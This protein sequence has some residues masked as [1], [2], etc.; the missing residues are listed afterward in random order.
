MQKYVDR[1][2]NITKVYQFSGAFFS[3]VGVIA[4]IILS[5]WLC[6]EI[7]RKNNELVANWLALTGILLSVFVLMLGVSYNEI[8]SC[9]SISYTYLSGTYPLVLAFNF[10]AIF[11]IIDKLIKRK[12]QRNDKKNLA[13]ARN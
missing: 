6:F 5:I 4:Y 10:I 13:K 2:N 7:K 12:G 3:V 9:F 8:A 11:S 1:L